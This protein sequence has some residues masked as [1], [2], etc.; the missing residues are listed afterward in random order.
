MTKP[1]FVPPALVTHVWH[2]AEAL[3]RPAME[4]D[5]LFSGDDILADLMLGQCQLWIAGNPIEAALVTAMTG[6]SNGKRLQLWFC[7]GRGNWGDLVETIA[8]AAHAPLRIEGRAGWAR[9]LPGFKQVGVIL[10][11]E[12][13]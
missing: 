8:E 11:R 6:G 9:V 1:Y 4:R 7:G 3:L 13:A 10:E 5:G 12:T 2:E